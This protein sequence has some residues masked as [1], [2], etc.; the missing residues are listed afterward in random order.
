MRASLSRWVRVLFGGAVLF[1]AT[2]SGCVADAFRDIGDDFDE[3][4]NE[5]DGGDQEE[6]DLWGDL[7][8]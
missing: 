4:A 8:G 2:E 3:W 6:D 1:A 5:I 7:F